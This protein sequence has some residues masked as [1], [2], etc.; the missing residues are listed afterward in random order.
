MDQL[1]EDEELTHWGQ[2]IL[3][4]DTTYVLHRDG[5]FS[6]R[7]HLITQIHDRND[8]TAW[9]EL[10]RYYV[11]GKSHL[12]IHKAM[13]YLPDGT[14]RKAHKRSVLNTDYNTRVISLVYSPLRPGVVIELETQFEQYSWEETGPGSWSE[15]PLGSTV[16]CRKVRTTLAI[17]S[18]FDPTMKLHHGAPEPDTTSQGNYKVHQWELDDRPGIEGDRWTP[19][20]RDFVPWIDISLLKS[21]IPIAEHY[22]QQIEPPEHTP[23]KVKST[24]QELTKD[25]QSPK[26]QVE[27]LYCYAAKDMR[28][29]RHHFELYEHTT[30]DP[31]AMMEDLRGDCKDKAALMVS[32]LRELGFEANIVVL[33]T[34]ASGLTPY[35]PGARFDHA[36]VRTIVEDEEIWLDPAADLFPFGSLPLND[37]GVSALV[38]NGEQSEYLTIPWGTPEEHAISRTSHGVIDLEGNYHFTTNIRARG[39]YAF[40]YRHQYLDRTQE[41]QARILAQGVTFNLAS[42]EVSEV[43]FQYFQ[44]SLFLSSERKGL[45]LKELDSITSLS[46]KTQCDHENIIPSPK[47]NYSL[48]QKS[49]SQQLSDWNTRDTD[50]ALRFFG[51][52]CCL[53]PLGSSRFWPLARHWLKHLPT[54]QFEMLWLPLYPR[55]LCWKKEFRKPFA[56]EFPKWSTESNDK[57]PSILP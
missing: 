23:S 18:H 19:M 53:L 1:P 31:V 43:K 49:G 37:Q 51:K 29:G 40:H 16:P 57:S 47:P 33:L 48:M 41:Y 30:R 13:V 12:K 54:K 42:A 2:V 10:V 44:I 50:V 28:Y 24:T 4:Q 22:Q 20:L 55:F 21:W 26:E 17:D 15:F 14:S 9:D 45:P 3:L 27:A 5:S 56:T 8:L 25:A 38:L 35:L 39:D 32:M 46:G 11:P 6:E 52:F 36:I 7:Y 34:R